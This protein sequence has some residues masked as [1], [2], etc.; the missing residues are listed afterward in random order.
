MEL[1]QQIIAQTEKMAAQAVIEKVVIPKRIDDKFTNAANFTFGA[2]GGYT[3]DRGG[4]TNY[5]ITQN[6]LDAY[7]KKNNR[8][9]ERVDKIKPEYAREIAKKEYFDAP[10][11]AAFPDNTAA[12]MFDFGFNAGP[13]RSTA[14]MQSIVGA[15]PDGING[16]KTK[17]AINQYIA[18]NGEGALLKNFTDK[19]KDYYIR[20]T[21]GEDPKVRRNGYMN[22]IGG[23]KNRLNVQ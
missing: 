7:N 4:P 12:A 19:I 18:K 2:E 3:V 6:T 15:K 1:L 23:M 10:G 13:A 5:G 11:Y 14:L 22:R 8:P 17:L 9:L 21:D 20:I 16:P